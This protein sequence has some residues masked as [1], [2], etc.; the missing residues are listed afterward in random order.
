MDA[1]W[2]KSPSV[3]RILLHW[4]DARPA[5]LWSADGATLMWRNL[6]ARYFYGKV[7]KHGIKLSPE[8]LP[9]KGQVSRVMRM[10]TNGRSSLSRLQF[11]V[12]E[13]PVSATCACT[14]LIL[15]DGQS[16]LLIVAV[17]PIDSTLLQE[18]LAGDDLSEAILPKGIEHLLFDADGQISGGSSHA[19]AAYAP[20]LKANGPPQFDADAKAHLS[21]D[22]QSLLLTRFTASPGGAS[23]VL[24]WPDASQPVAVEP[25][26]APP[27]AGADPILDEWSADGADDAPILA[28]EQ[29][30]ERFAPEEAELMEDDQSTSTDESGHSPFTPAT[31]VA[32]EDGVKP[33]DAV[34][35][36]DDLLA[37][38]IETESW[39]EP[40][41]IGPEIEPE[42]VTQDTGD[43]TP[44]ERAMKSLTD[45]FDKLISDQRLFT[46]LDAG[47]D[48]APEQNPTGAEA[49]TAV[50]PVAETAPEA[51]A[52]AAP[53]EASDAVPSL[54]K[55][56]GRGF[57][58]Q[59]AA[60][61]APTQTA[62][63]EE[64]P[65][66][67]SEASA[68]PVPPA[69][70]ETVE[71]V[72]RYNFD[73]L[74]RILT[75]RI[76]AEGVGMSSGAGA[77]LLRAEKPATSAAPDSG[78][79]TLGG[80]TF[81]LNRLPLG[82]VVFRDQQVLFANR[83]LTDLTGYESVES[84]RTAGIE[85][86]FPAVEAVSG[87][88]GPLHHLVKRDGM[89]VP[90]NARLQTISWQ[91]R[92]ALMLSASLSENT[93]G[94]EA[95]VRAFAE[96]LADAGEDGFVGTDRSGVITSLSGH[97]SVL[98]GHPASEL[99]GRPLPS[100]IAAEDGKALRAFFERP[101]RFAETA[102]P[103]ISLAGLDKDIE[104]LLFAEGQ[105]GIVA[106]YFGFVRRRL[107]TTQYVATPS[108]P[109]IEP[110][111]LA[112]ISRGIRRPLNSILGFSDLIANHGTDAARTLEYASDIRNSGQEIAVLVNEL[113]DYT[114][115][116]EGRYPAKRADTELGVLLETLVGRVRGLANER[117][118]LVR[119]AVSERL[120]RINADQPSLTQAMLN[121]LASAIDQTPSGG[122][123][124]L[125]AKWADDG[126]IDIHVRSSAELSANL[127]D[128]FVVFR[129]GFGKN[130]EVLAP[131][132]SSIGLS[133][134][135]ALLAVNSCSLSVNPTAAAGTLF[136]M[137]VPA[138]LVVEIP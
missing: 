58:T 126:S 132:R 43:S 51:P 96:I 82:I 14:P 133:L 84:L 123:V 83:A 111:L 62:P 35:L 69:D 130:G 122:S 124:V 134:T 10:G 24:F 44:D 77:T 33:D 6:S 104:I 71:R 9:I 106:G 73:E 64:A 128:Q 137:L 37:S 31:P 47:D 121:L 7:K 91:G 17:D 129:D 78:L 101:A 103:G 90:V 15:E 125:S 127:P 1:D 20:A 98:L 109:D 57:A 113:D 93:K 72:S 21:V 110:G 89:L 60:P 100:I 65:K 76:G 45:L 95:A 74:A 94:H 36:E 66:A 105:A 8:A 50:E 86:M 5:W 52:E 32:A 70:S 2:I 92:P 114:R 115:L 108:E 87:G 68:P 67:E 48:H 39:H 38:G 102:R 54:Y 12:G 4:A 3:R 135:R 49:P 85:A 118:V 46:P 13:K 112:R 23:L 79:V 75:D 97:A 138:D 16:A 99:I 19:L 11:L 88:N 107:T 80:E 136:S 26:E 131:V 120:P 42:P 27:V 28:E 34:R 29:S 59:A 41:D 53:E 61:E 18:P 25:P 63:A 81:V 119:S 40:L 117:R 116:K 22:G 56:T 55:V 30:T